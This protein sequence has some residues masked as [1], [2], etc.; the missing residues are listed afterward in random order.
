V[1]TAAK[2]PF[3]ASSIEANEKKPI[4]KGVGF[5]FVSGFAFRWDEAGSSDQEKPQDQ[6]DS[7]APAG[8]CLVL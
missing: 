2:L 8:I 7:T 5:F 6:Q 4:P 3:P 1:G